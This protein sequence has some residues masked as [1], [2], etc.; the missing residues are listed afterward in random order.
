MKYFTMVKTDL[1]YFRSLE[2]ELLC[3]RMAV[4]VL[5]STV[6]PTPQFYSLLSKSNWIFKNLSRLNTCGIQLLT[7]STTENDS[8]PLF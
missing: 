4:T 6:K 2:K 3:Q 7:Q 5:Q 8:L 1:F